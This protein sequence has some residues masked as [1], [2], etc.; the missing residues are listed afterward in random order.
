MNGGSLMK[1]LPKSLHMGLWFVGTMWL[2]GILGYFT[3]QGIDLLLGVFL[4]GLIGVA[5]EWRANNQ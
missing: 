4:M 1:N 3:G 2:V 5:M